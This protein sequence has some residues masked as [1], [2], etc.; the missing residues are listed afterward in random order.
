VQ[1]KQP[2]RFGR[3]I[4]TSP[5]AA[6]ALRALKKGNAAFRHLRAGFERKLLMESGTGRWIVPLAL[7]HRRAMAS[8]PQQ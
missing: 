8:K 4:G 1:A 5:G 7:A 6:E 3:T 2:A